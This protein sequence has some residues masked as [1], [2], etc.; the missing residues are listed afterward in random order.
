MAPP[1]PW[2]G[3][4][5][6][7]L[8]YEA[9][10]GVEGRPP[11]RPSPLGFPTLWLGRYEALLAW[12]HRDATAWVVGEGRGEREARRRA[13]RLLARIEAPPAP[14]RPWRAGPAVGTVARE[15]YV[16]R[17]AAARQAVLDGT[18]FQTNLSHRFD[19]P[20][21]GRT[22]DLFDR[23]ARLQA[24]PYMTYLGLGDGRAVLS[25]SPERFLRVA[26]DL[27]ETDPMK[28]TRR[29]GATED[30]DRRLREELERSDKERAELAMIVDLSRNDLSRVCRPGSVRVRI[31]RRLL[32]FVRV[33][34]AIAVVEGRLEEGRDGVDAVQAAFPP[35][36]VTGAPKIAAM[37]VLDALEGEGR[38]PYCGTLGWFDAAGDADLA[39]GIR[40]IVVGEG[41]ASWRVGG[42]VTLRSDPAEEWE[43]TLAKGATL[44]LALGLEEPV[45]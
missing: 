13:D 9:R 10:S 28:G 32:P 39:V 23:F 19:A 18:I 31:A 41:R 44:A 26:G 3:G 34:Q 17:V 37:E 42:G 45:P 2:T 40:T 29:R 1:L 20:F 5:A 27:V 38:G 30:E 14:P 36:S 12:N 24:A 25:G 43:E 15:E 7:L 35:G 21:E 8:G 16:R 11:P 22:V 4:W 6:G 33:H